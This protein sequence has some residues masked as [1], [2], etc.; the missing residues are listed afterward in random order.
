MATRRELDVR[1]ENEMLVASAISV[2]CLAGIAFY[3]RFLVAL[4]REYRPRLIGYRVRLRLGS[5]P[6]MTVR[7]QEQERK[8][9]R[10][11]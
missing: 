6:E 10:A 9:A 5:V 8:V 3:L 1:P 7:A 11:A 2:L 4:C